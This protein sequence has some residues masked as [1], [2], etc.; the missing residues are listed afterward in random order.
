MATASVL[1]VCMPFA[2]V[3]KPSLALSLLQGTLA[4]GNVRSDVLYPSLSFASLIGRPLY[5]YIAG[6][7][8]SIQLLLGEWLFSGDLD[9]GTLKREAEYLY[10]L[11]GP[12]LS[13]R[14]TVG[15]RSL[16]PKQLVAELR[17]VRQHVSPYLDRIARDILRR[18]P[19]VV[20]FTSAFQ[21]HVASLCLA[22]RLKAALPEASIVFGGA[23][24]ESSM[25]LETIRQFPFVDAVVSGEGDGV[26]FQLITR[27][28]SGDSCADL[29]GVVCRETAWTMLQLNNAPPVADLDTLPIPDYGS[30]F[31]QRAS[32]FKEIRSPAAIPFET[33][34]GCW[35]GEK[36]HCTFCGL[37]G[38][39][40][41][42][43]SKSTRRALLELDELSARHPGLLLCAADNI[44]DMRYFGEFNEALAARN[45]QLQLFFETKAN[46]SREQVRRLSAAGIKSIQPGIESLSDAVLRSM[47][48]GTTALQ[49]IQ[50]LRWCRE[51]GVTASWS[52]LH[53]FP[54]ERR[55]DY[56]DMARLLPKLT[57]LDAPLGCSRLR[58]D[59]FSPNFM[60][61]ETHGFRNVEPAR[62][63]SLIYSCDSSSLMRLAYFFEFQYLENCESSLSIDG[64]ADAV[65][66]WREAQ[67]S[68]VLWS[69]DAGSSLW[70]IDTRPIAS[71][72]VV[73]LGALA[74][75][76]TL[77]CD[78]VR[79]F[80]QILC[81]SETAFGNAAR[82]VVEQV[83]LELEQ[84]GLMV[85]DG[86]RIL[87]LPVAS[88]GTAASHIAA[89]IG[90][91][92]NRLTPGA[93]V[94]SLL[95]QSVSL[96]QG[97]IPPAPGAT[98]E[99]HYTENRRPAPK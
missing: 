45:V 51:F 31:A 69:W 5:H 43:R 62:A 80:E 94:R 92:E 71:Q 58:L 1:F 82:G 32:H 54:G 98:R 97:T 67:K 23:N 75:W 3:G 40:M 57:H 26:V 63:Y 50:L 66:N 42:F 78:R 88:S 2:D 96:A 20:G 22:R 7:H 21:Q 19:R 91:W 48:K 77:Q 86:D 65:A 60:E 49:N 89:K 39:N 25:G 8:P 99:L 41:A 93:C 95:D 28:L 38:G 46:L 30:Y 47:R 37:N 87:S 15:R 56:E 34:R 83:A 4:R 36:H 70:V 44:L 85:R 53:G 55:G 13:P 90:T 72:P 33:S 14:T 17:A 16:T 81:E 73:Y 52:I 35:W 76:L 11:L 29:P 61:P 74:R 59:R 9:P 84:R 24:C 12:A 79:V 64:V 18:Q 10:N 6:G 68:S 27:L